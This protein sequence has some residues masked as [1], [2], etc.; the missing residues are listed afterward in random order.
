MYCTRCGNKLQ[1]ENIFCGKCGKK[2][3]APAIIQQAP[4]NQKKKNIFGFVGFMLAMLSLFLLTFNE[5]IYSVFSILLIYVLPGL[6]FSIVGMA[7]QRHC[8]LNIFAILGL[9]SNILLIHLFVFI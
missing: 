5:T 9:V 7:K 6:A 3:V 8:Y 4:I 2:V 1:T